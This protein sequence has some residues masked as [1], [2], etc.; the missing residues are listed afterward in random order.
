MCSFKVS[1]PP[2]RCCGDAATNTGR[3]VTPP[4]SHPPPSLVKNVWDKAPAHQAAVSRWI[5][6]LWPA[7]WPATRLQ[8]DDSAQIFLNSVCVLVVHK[9][10]GA[11]EFYITVRQPSS[12]WLIGKTKIMLS[13]FANALGEPCRNKSREPSPCRE[14]W[15]HR[16]FVTSRPKKSVRPLPAYRWGSSGSRRGHKLLRGIMLASDAAEAEMSHHYGFYWYFC[17]VP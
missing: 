12:L 11:G 14:L 16:V 17:K 13:H 6:P 8:R 2:T 4:H 10:V 7:S 1:L 15:S 5:Q 9:G 3:L